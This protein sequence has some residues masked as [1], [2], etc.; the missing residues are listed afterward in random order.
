MPRQSMSIGMLL[1]L[2]PKTYMQIPAA[3]QGVAKP[4][5]P[6]AAATAA[7]RAARQ[8]KRKEVPGSPEPENTRAELRMVSNPCSSLW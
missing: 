6:S 3:R 1:L 8:R 5:P 2:N 7:A 4:A